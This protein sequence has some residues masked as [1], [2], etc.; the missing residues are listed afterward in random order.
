[1]QSEVKRGVLIGVAC[2]LIGG[3]GYY[4]TDPDILKALFVGGIGLVVS[5][6]I[7]VIMKFAGG[8]DSARET[9]ENRS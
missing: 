5:L 9:T 1:M 8:Q 6:L 2:A 3:L 7:F 4:V